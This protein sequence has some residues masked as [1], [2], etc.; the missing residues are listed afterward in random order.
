MKQLALGQI[1]YASDNDERFPIAGKWADLIYPYTKTQE[2]LKC[3][4]A[5]TPQ[6]YAMNEALSSNSMERLSSPNQT[7]LLFEADAYLSN[8]SGGRE[9]FVRRH[10]DTGSVAFTDGHAKRVNA[11]ITPS[12]NWRP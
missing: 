8:A 1:M 11:Y 2:I 4:D 10:H 7:V 9:W 6:S 3:P 5:K 12:L